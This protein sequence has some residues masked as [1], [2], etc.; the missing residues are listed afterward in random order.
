MLFYLKTDIEGITIALRFNLYY[1][2][3]I[4]LKSIMNT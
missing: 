3:F 4:L 2:F 1:T